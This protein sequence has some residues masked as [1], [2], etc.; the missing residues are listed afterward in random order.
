MLSVVLRGREIWSGT[1]KEKHALSDGVWEQS[2]EEN[3]II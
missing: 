2:A 1:W 3:I